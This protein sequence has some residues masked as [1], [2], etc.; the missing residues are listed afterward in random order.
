VVSIEVKVTGTLVSTGFSV[1]ILSLQEKKIK[2][3]KAINKIFFSLIYSL[4]LQ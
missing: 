2:A 1:S 3:N 4:K